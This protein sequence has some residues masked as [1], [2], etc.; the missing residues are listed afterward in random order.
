ME[1]P[2]LNRRWSLVNILFRAV[3]GKPLV[4]QEKTHLDFGRQ[5]AFSSEGAHPMSVCESNPEERH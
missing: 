4:L 3:S 1:C 2:V 5:R